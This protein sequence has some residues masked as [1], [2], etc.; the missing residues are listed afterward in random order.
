MAK[1]KNIFFVLVG[2]HLVFT[3]SEYK[4]YKT[5]NNNVFFKYLFYRNLN[6]KLCLLQ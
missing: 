1:L 5:F 6:N 2:N 4:I 3:Y